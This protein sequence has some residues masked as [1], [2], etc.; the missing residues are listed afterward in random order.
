MN[1]WRTNTA[2][3]LW[4][5][6]ARA[7]GLGRAGRIHTPP[8]RCTFACAPQPKHLFGSTLWSFAFEKTCTG[9]D[10]H[11]RQM[12]EITIPADKAVEEL[13]ERF[14]RAGF[15]YRYESGKI[16][17]VDSEFQHQEATR[18]ALELLSDPR[19]AGANEEFRAAYDHLKAG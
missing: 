12:L 11:Q 17:R 2:L 10:K 18:P 16:F 8:S 5:T 1:E 14:R 19:F 4:R 13:N 15:G 9:Y 6:S 7:F 3:F